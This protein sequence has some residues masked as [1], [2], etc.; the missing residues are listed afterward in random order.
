[1]GVT[2]L[3]QSTMFLFF[4][5]FLLQT[6]SSAL[7][8]ESITSSAGSQDISLIQTTPE[9]TT[10]ITVE[11]TSKTT[12]EKTTKTTT[13]TTTETVTATLPAYIPSTLDEI[14]ADILNDFAVA[15]KGIFRH[16]INRFHAASEEIFLRYRPFVENASDI[17]D[18]TVAE[19]QD[20]MDDLYEAA[21]LSYSTQSEELL[22]KYKDQQF[23]PTIRPKV[24]ARYREELVNLYGQH[25]DEYYS[26]TEEY[27]QWKLD[28]YQGKMDQFD[29][30]YYQWKL[31][32]FDDEY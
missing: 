16:N 23:T 13:E 32:Q 27:Y 8:N 30:E 21:S 12:T 31:R 2:G 5:I 18:T 17:H 9:T 4:P 20:T 29:D 19:F 3:H 24:V 25:L 11:N 26:S 1:M 15:C 10:G 22:K 6:V 14:H 7:L 28:Q